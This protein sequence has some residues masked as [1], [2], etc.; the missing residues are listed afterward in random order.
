MNSILVS[1]SEVSYH[2][3]THS[4]T[5]S[6]SL[7]HED[8]SKSDDVPTRSPGEYGLFSVQTTY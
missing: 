1:N 6:F 8:F 7:I 4:L 5:H 3:L 2:S